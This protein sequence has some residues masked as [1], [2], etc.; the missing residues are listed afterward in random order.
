VLKAL[1]G[2]LQPAL[3]YYKKF[4]KDIE[5]IGFKINPYDPCIAN[6]IINGNQRTITWHVDDMKSSHVDKTV[7]GKFLGWLQSMCASDGVGKVKAT[8]GLNHEYL[9]MNFNYTLPGSLKID[10]TKYV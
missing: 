9:G 10:M 7:N 1:Y 2:M 4:R 8:R 3:L 6:R 5:R